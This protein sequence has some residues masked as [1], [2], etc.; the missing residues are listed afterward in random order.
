M[1]TK[2]ILVTEPANPIQRRLAIRLLLRPELRIVCFRAGANAQ[3]Y[4]LREITA[5]HEELRFRNCDH[6]SVDEVWHSK[7]PAHSFE[8]SRAAMQRVLPF[9]RQGKVSVIHYVSTSQ[10]TEETLGGENGSHAG[11]TA[12]SKEEE[13]DFWNERALEESGCR[14]RIY[15]IPLFME[16][17][18]GATNAWTRFVL[19]LRR[20][21]EE[22]E[23][24]I[25][26]YFTA[27]A[28][29]I[30]LSEEG[31]VSLARVDDIIH[32]LEE[33]SM[34]SDLTSRQFHI[35]VR[36]PMPLSDYFPPLARLTGLRL[37]VVSDEKQSNLVDRLFAVRMREFLPYL[38]GK[39]TTSMA[40]GNGGEFFQIPQATAQDLLRVTGATGSSS[41]AA[42]FDWKAG[43]ERKQLV[44]PEGVPLNYYKGG[45]GEKTLVL[46]N[47][48]GQSFGYWEKFIHAMSAQT[49][50]VLWIPRGNEFE[51]PGQKLASPHRTHADDLDRVLTNE[52]IAS[53]TLVAWCSGPKLALEYYSR[54]SHRVSSMVFIAPSFKGLARYKALE[55]DY[56][57]NLEPLLETVEKYPETA[58]VVLEYLR[59]ILLA[60]S[61]QTRSIEQL[62]S[63][64]DKELQDALT[65]VNV[66]LQELVLE[67]FCAANVV[68]YAKQMHDFW[69]HEFL[70]GLDAVAVPVLFVGG[71]CDRIASQAIAKAV[72]GV[73]PRAKY[74]EI[75]GG[76][77]YIHYE[78]W[79]MLAQVVE[80]VVN[81]VG[82]VSP[83]AVRGLTEPSEKSMTM[84]QGRE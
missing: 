47:A 54:Y 37:Q 48:Y 67:P 65:A 12:Q 8:E 15:R 78:Q 27:N 72:A 17:I 39:S 23:G 18:S 82:E 69:R 79:D 46:I 60:Q 64:S 14:F 26:G 71:D 2:T 5:G 63:I 80:D 32:A 51:T 81:A 43:F 33:T 84:R 13:C 6:T 24:R 53:C 59:G 28:L 16:E 49:R 34:R 40:P 61:K 29:R 35:S 68:A 4:P 19:L 76:T 22:I 56:E 62:A 57:K 52:N 30:H 73:I 36:E 10:R 58:G 77:H 1:P 25:P 31:T 70:P 38:T 50:V 9:V 83:S 74:L 42:T 44:F 21:R 45:R 7:N 75:K 20:F 3:E 11:K 55:T 41:H 66:N